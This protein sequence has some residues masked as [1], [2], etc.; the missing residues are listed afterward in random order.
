[1][2][3]WDDD[4]HVV[5]VFLAFA[6]LLTSWKITVTSPDSCKG[7]FMEVTT[8]PL[9]E[10]I[11]TCQ[12]LRNYNLPFHW[13]LSMASYKSY[14]AKHIRPLLCKVRL[15]YQGTLHFETLD[16]QGFSSHRFG[17]Q[18]HRLYAAIWQYNTREGLPWRHHQSAPLLWSKQN[19]QSNHDNFILPN[20]P[21]VNFET[22]EKEAQGSLHIWCLRFTEIPL[23]LWI[24]PFDRF[25]HSI[26]SISLDLPSQL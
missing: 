15:G 5:H 14:S 6:L 21:V 24:Q 22:T 9:L 20:L 19:V 10:T 13:D 4:D 11:S 1:M 17:A 18:T 25:A 2:Y 26:G 16:F 12:S 23:K 7:F 8:L 3:S